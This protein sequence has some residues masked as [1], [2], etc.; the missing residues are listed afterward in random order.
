MVRRPINPKLL[1]NVSTRHLARHLAAL[2]LVST[3]PSLAWA[4]PTPPTA[5]FPTTPAPSASALAAEPIPA[6]IPPPP[7]AV[8]PAPVAPAPVAPAPIA[9]APELAP[10][11]APS[12]QP[13]PGAVISTQLAAGSSPSTADATTTTQPSTSAAVAEPVGAA[14]LAAEPASVPPPLPS[15]EARPFALTGSL[16][17][18]SLAGFALGATYSFDPHVSADIAFGVGTIGLKTGA[19][20]RYNLF[21][22][23]WTPSFGLGVQYGPGS[24]RSAVF[25]GANQGE[26]AELLVESSAFAQGIAAMSYQ[27]QSGFTALFGLGYS[28]LLDAD[29]VRHLS[30]SEETA[31]A[32]R[33]VTGSGMVFEIALGYAF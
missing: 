31:D 13:P 2:S 28:V 14:A 8:A 29:N 11:Q 23:S 26:E 4:Q 17:W 7:A 20:V 12:A 5:Q 24:V 33:F 6:P 15:R 22:S 9:P 25:K 1:S 19:R 3:Y 18:N 27:G 30:G 10:A 16:G 32:V 21:E